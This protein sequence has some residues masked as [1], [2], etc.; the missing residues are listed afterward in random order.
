M[1]NSNGLKLFIR[2]NLEFEKYVVPI[3]YKYYNSTVI[4]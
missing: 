1:S 4:C 3:T 2:V